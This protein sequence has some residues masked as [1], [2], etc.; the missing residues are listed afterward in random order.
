M[1]FSLILLQT[2]THNLCFWAKI[3]KNN[4]NL[5]N[6]IFPCMKW[7][8]L[9]C[10]LMWCWKYSEDILDAW[11]MILWQNLQ[12]RQLYQIS[13]LPG[14]QIL[15]FFFCVLQ[16][17]MVNSKANMESQKLS[18]VRRVEKSVPVNKLQIETVQKIVTYIIQHPWCWVKL[19]YFT[20]HIF[21]RN[22]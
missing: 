7:S 11:W 1:I 16:R 5:L 13:S 4:V 17:G 14:K 8:F 2:S 21:D 10:S 9:G 3:K 20:N 18:C 19:I 6:P 22:W 12:D 15:S